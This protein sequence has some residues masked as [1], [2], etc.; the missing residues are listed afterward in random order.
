MEWVDRGR[1]VTDRRMGYSVYC[2]CDAVILMDPGRIGIGMATT[3]RSCLGSL[4]LALYTVLACVLSERQSIAP[5]GGLMPPIE[6][7]P[8]GLGCW[9][10]AAL[11][12][13]VPHQS[14]LV[15]RRLR[16]YGGIDI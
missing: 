6:P 1:T 10:G 5:L 15:L 13:R 12:G 2:L 8:P 9:S 14:G 11:P 16:Y 3:M 4:L 7:P